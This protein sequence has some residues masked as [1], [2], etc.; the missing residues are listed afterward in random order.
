MYIPT[1]GLEIH[2]EPNT[3]SKMFCRCPNKREAAKPN[4]NVCPICLGHPGAMPVPNVEAIK[5][6]IKLGLALNGQIAEYSHFD[7]KSYFY[8]DLP[9]NYQISQYEHP[10]V[11]GGVLNNI[12]IT[13]IHLEEDAGKLIHA[14][15]GKTLV[16]YNR[17]GV[18]LIELVTEPDIKS[19]D[20]AVRFA[21]DLQSI[22]R[23]I[24][25]SNADM[26]NGEMRLEANIS[27]RKNESD[28][29]G[30]KV[31]VKNLNSF[32]SMSDA[33]NYELK[34]QEEVLESG[35]RIIQETRGWNVLKNESYSQR[36]KEG[37]SDYRYLP[38]PDM[39][40]F[41]LTDKEFIDIDLLRAGIPELPQAKV[42]RFISEYQISEDQASSLSE[43]KEISGYFENTASEI[44][45]DTSDWK[46][47]G[48]A[49]LF[50]LAA[51]YIVSD[52]KSILNSINGDLKSL[53]ITPENM[54]DLAILIAKGDLSSRMAKDILVEMAES[55]LDPR[56]IIETKGLKQVSDVDSI[57]LVVQEIINNNPVVVADYRKGKQNALQY[58][59]GQSM[60]KLKG[61]G[62]PIVIKTILEE[63]LNK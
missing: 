21:K 28:K 32:K 30:T 62:N 58:L 45:E 27:V 46:E 16:D 43:N 25:I 39:P 56:T 19:G 49:K 20:E 41:D 59:I 55:G 11:S 38:E 48:R 33:I 36:I 60:A 6:I 26:E 42:K 37:A 52:L 3:E 13:R 50:I 23:Y 18:P 57:R 63:E 9:K 12:R 47:T 61:Q 40:S 34:R 17:G 1:I 7:R 53:K 8:P 24:G 5:S 4:Q 14:S 10:F 2:I 35:G 44:I 15:N 22:I 54:A 51:N 31:E 29:L